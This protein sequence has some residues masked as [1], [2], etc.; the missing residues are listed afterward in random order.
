MPTDNLLIELGY[1]VEVC[2]PQLECLLGVVGSDPPDIVDIV[3]KR[4]AQRLSVEARLAANIED[5]FGRIG[6]AR[7]KF[8]EVTDIRVY[9]AGRIQ[10]G[11]R[12]RL[13]LS[14]NVTEIMN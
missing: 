8:F 12:S 14:G 1:D 5:I 10:T 7:R 4:L 3:L 6:A 13:D 9:G 2:N 11:R